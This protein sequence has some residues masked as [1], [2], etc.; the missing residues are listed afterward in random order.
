MYST[1]TIHPSWL[2]LIS[3]WLLANIRSTAAA[4]QDSNTTPTSNSPAATSSI[5]SLQNEISA[6]LIPKIESLLNTPNKKKA[7]DTIDEIDKVKPGA[8]VIPIIPFQFQSYFF[9]GLNWQQNVAN[10]LTP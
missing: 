6:T 5:H 8:E 1:L 2:A 9:C 7:Q 10:E 4:P 3:L